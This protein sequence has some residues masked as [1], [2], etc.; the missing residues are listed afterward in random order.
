MLSIPPAR[1]CPTACRKTIIKAVSASGSHSD[2]DSISAGNCTQY[3]MLVR[4]GGP[5]Y[6]GLGEKKLLL[7][8]QLRRRGQRDRQAD[9]GTCH[10]PDHLKQSKILAVLRRGEK[11]IRLNDTFPSALAVQ[12]LQQG[13][14]RR[15]TTTPISTRSSCTNACKIKCPIGIRS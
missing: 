4:S 11:P 8:I 9:K 7:Q 10:A 5:Q 2:L 6:L 13:M 14:E 15:V 1:G 3:R 12:N